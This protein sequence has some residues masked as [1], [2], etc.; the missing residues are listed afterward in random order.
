[1]SSERFHCSALASARR[2]TQYRADLRRH[3]GGHVCSW[4]GAARLV[5]CLLPHLERLGKQVFDVRE[6]WAHFMW[7]EASSTQ[8]ALHS[9]TV[10]ENSRSRRC[11][12]GSFLNAVRAERP[13][14]RRKA[15]PTSHVAEPTSTGKSTKFVWSAKNE[16]LR[17][18]N[19][20]DV[21]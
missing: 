4:G 19:L 16:Y 17:R 7:P 2:Q 3:S 1:M 13:C 9:C 5:G 20:R 14:S 21:F 8:A 6:A 10:A 15:E 11:G 18:Y 12:R